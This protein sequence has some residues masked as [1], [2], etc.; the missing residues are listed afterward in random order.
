MRRW[1][2]ATLCFLLLGLGGCGGGGGGEEATLPGA[3][4]APPPA[5]SRN[6]STSPGSA[7]PAR[8]AH[9]KVTEA[10]PERVA[11]VLPPQV[12]KRLERRLAESAVTPDLD[13]LIVIEQGE[14]VRRPVAGGGFSKAEARTRQANPEYRPEGDSQPSP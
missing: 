5:Q 9:G 11:R 12:A 10:E 13:R 6:A 1:P 4:T 7:T 14:V 8:S 2:I 3:A